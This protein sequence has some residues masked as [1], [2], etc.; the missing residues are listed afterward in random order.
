MQDME[1]QDGRLW[2]PTT[3]K[4]VEAR[5]WTSLDVVLFSNDASRTAATARKGGLVRMGNFS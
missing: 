2:L 5:G 1:R 4:E 3:R